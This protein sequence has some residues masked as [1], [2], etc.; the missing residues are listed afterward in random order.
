MP[1][2]RPTYKFDTTPRWVYM[3]LR[4]HPN[5]ERIVRCGV[6]SVRGHHLGLLAR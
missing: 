4:P 6:H 2:A 3:L 1:A 5:V